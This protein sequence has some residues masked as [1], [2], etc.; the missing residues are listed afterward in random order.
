MEGG[1][2]RDSP[3]ILMGYDAAV[4]QGRTRRRRDGNR[5]GSVELLRPVVAVCPPD[6]CIHALNGDFSHKNKDS[7]MNH[8]M[9]H[10]KHK[11]NIILTFPRKLGFFC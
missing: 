3:S 2:E 7:E 9:F 5:N 4:Y 1:R 11:V 8:K 10:E 6:A